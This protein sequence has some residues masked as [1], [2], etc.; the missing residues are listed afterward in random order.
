MVVVEGEGQGTPDAIGFGE[1]LLG[2][3]ETGSFTTSYKYALLLA[4]LDETLERTRPD[5]SPPTVLSGRE[6]GRRVFE[7]YWRQA[8]PFADAGPLRQSGM[9]DIVVKL[10][11]LRRELALPEH[12]SVDEARR[13]HA[14][15][16]RRV[17]RDVVATVIRY[18]IPRLQRF[19]TGSQYVEDRFVYDIGWSE[20]VTTARVHRAD[21]DDRLHLAPRAGQHLIALSGLLR[22][23]VEREWLRHVAR[24]NEHQVEELRLEAFLF[25]SQRVS[26]EPVMRPL[27]ELQAGRCFYCDRER[28]GFEVDHFLPW[29]RLPDDRLDNLVVAHARC[30]NAKRVAL[31]GLEHLARW[32]QRFEPGSRI[33]RRLTEV[34]EATR[35]PRHRARTAAGARGLYLHQPAGTLLWAER[36]R[37]EPLD[38]DRL[39][40]VLLAG[41]LA[42]E[43]PGTYEPR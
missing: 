16:V 26:L 10:A 17:E 22:P 11:E 33:D 31:A 42:A 8:R 41:P 18:P 23:V 37:V 36:Q 12:V 6:L 21:F 25:G 4:L 13:R 30:N 38:A 1:K 19:V 28:D 35:W 39:R 43:D 27:L 5:G 40:E 15:E 20:H 3:L 7:L 24:R 34:A 29:S 14:L 2:L 9:R 32:S